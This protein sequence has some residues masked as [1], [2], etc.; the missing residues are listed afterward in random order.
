VGVVLNAVDE[1]HMQASYYYQGYGYGNGYG[2]DDSKA[3]AK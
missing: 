2:H 3:V 1:D